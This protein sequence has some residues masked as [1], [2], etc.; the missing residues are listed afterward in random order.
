MWNKFIK[1]QRKE[2]RAREGGQEERKDGVRRI[3]N[4]IKP[5]NYDNTKE[6]KK[7]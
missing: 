6:I 3:R 5:R 4:Q 1:T 7:I 2:E